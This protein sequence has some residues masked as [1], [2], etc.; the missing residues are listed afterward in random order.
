MST[1]QTRRA[2][3]LAEAERLR[4]RLA[5]IAEAHSK[6]VDSAGGSWGDCT[7]CGWSWPCPT[8][9]WATQDRDVLAPWSP[10]DDTEAS[11]A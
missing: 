9:A 4:D 3:E 8:H 2:R 1:D 10:I 11:D 5:R 6:N 7:E